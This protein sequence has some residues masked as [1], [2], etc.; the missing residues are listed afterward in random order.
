MGECSTRKGGSLKGGGSDLDSFSLPRATQWPQKKC[1]KGHKRVFFTSFL[2]AGVDGPA[3]SL[4]VRG[5]KDTKV[6]LNGT[7]QGKG[8]ASC[9]DAA[10]ESLNTSTLGTKRRRLTYFIEGS[11]C[12]S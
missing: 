11:K 7:V 3:C 6:H 2:L 8:F 5:G 4:R 1:S 9:A 12:L 10:L